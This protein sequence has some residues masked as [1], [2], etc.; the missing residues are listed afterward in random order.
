M[1]FA[2]TSFIPTIWDVE[3]WE[4]IR[5]SVAYRDHRAQATLFLLSKSSKIQGFPQ[6]FEDLLNKNWVAGAL[7]SRWAT[8][9]IILSHES[10]CQMM[11]ITLE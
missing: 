1:D 8:E 3:S 5:F 6:N 11:G 4:T 2:D 10:T 7:S 9:K